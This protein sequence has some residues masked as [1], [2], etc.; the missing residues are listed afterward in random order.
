M[1]GAPSRY[2]LSMCV[3][4][5]VGPVCAKVQTVKAEG[6]KQDS[7]VIRGRRR[8]LPGLSVKDGFTLHPFDAE[9]GGEDQWDWWRDGI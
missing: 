8:L 5:V 1:E 2:G 7:G 3:A 6:K 9:F 4:T